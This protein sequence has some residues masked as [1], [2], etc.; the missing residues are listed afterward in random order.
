MYG[1][2]LRN[3]LDQTSIPSGKEGYYFL[4]AGETTWKEISEYIAVTGKK[5]GDFASE[6]VKEVSVEELTTLVGNSFLG[7]SMV[8]LVWGSK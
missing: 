2:I 5:H 1:I 7:P 6:D 8:E 3:V 4:D